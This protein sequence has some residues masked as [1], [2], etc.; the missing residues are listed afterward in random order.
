[1]PESSVARSFD[2]PNVQLKCHCGW[3]GLDADVTDWDVQSDRNRV[4]RKCPNCGEAVPEWGALP[5]V[6]G[7]RRI[8]RGPLAEALADAGRLDEDHA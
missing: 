5:T 6:D 8:A 2:H 1:M 4:V 7:A 3:T